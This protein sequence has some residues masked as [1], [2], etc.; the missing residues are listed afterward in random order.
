VWAGA[1]NSSKASRA[2]AR[3]LAVV[4]LIYSRKMG[5][6]FHRAKALKASMTSISAFA[7]TLAIRARL[8]RS[9]FYSII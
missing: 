8:R 1:P 9:F 5:K 2:S 4:E 7:A 6:V 3:E